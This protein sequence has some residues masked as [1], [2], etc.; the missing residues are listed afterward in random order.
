M[1]LIKFSSFKIQSVVCEGWSRV[2]GVE[3]V[4]LCDRVGEARRC[5][6]VIYLPRK[7]ATLY[8]RVGF[9]FPLSCPVPAVTKYPREASALGLTDKTEP[10]S[11]SRRESLCACVSVL[12]VNSK[13]VD[14]FPLNVF[15][16]L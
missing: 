7:S 9:S 8:I 15:Y 6:L 16:D 3:V 14:S 10:R 4:T 2:V 13:K 5:N 11:L 12:T 1:N